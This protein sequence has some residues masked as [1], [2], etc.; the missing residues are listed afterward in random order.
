VQ[1]TNS[2]YDV[3]VTDERLI[4]HAG[5]GLLAELA[6]RIGLTELDRAGP[7]CARTRWPAR[8]HPIPRILHDLVVML[9]DGSDCLSG[10]RLLTIAAPLLGDGPAESRSERSAHPGRPAPTTIEITYEPN[11]SIGPYRLP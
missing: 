3:I 10:L 5:V 2:P 7:L 4:S 8:Q 9:A 1:P 11:P 6:D